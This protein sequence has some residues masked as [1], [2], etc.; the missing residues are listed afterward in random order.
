[1][2]GCWAIFADRL[3]GEQLLV[4]AVWMDDVA[5]VVVAQHFGLT[6]QPER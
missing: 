1:M 4:Q 3:I 2:W 6:I 5:L